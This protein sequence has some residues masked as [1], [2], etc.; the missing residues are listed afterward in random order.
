MC[1]CGFDIAN[2][3]SVCL[4]S[5][6]TSSEYLS[7]ESRTLVEDRF[8]CK[9][10]DWY[11]QFERVAA[12]ANCEHGRYHVLTDYSHVELLNSGN[13]R[14]EIVGTNF[15]NELYPLVRYKTGDH[16]LLSDETTCPCGRVYPLVKGIEGRVVDYVYAS[17]G[18]QVFALDQC[19]K[20]VAGIVGSQYVQ[21]KLG[22]IE[23]RIVAGTDF[24]EAALS[25]LTDNVK[26]RLGEDMSVSVVEVK[27]L[28]RTQN[29]KVRQAICNIKE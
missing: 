16:V 13:G 27:M 5:I 14:Y 17:S 25:K 20:G 24:N 21:D 7:P 19:V 4:N 12:I 8:R 10:F 22:Q 26:K 23:V 3:N 9:V 29:G 15:N 6:I 11:G 1:I 2:C 28:E 18:Q